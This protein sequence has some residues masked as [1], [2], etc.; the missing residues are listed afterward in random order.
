MSSSATVA[1]TEDAGLKD[2]KRIRF[3]LNFERER[4]QGRLR[5]KQVARQSH[6]ALVGTLRRG[7]AW[8]IIAFPPF[9]VPA[10]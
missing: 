10:A 6:G 5:N 4:Q 7:G 9:F 1:S 8:M 2:T 3:S